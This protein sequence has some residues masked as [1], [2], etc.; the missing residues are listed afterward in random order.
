MIRTIAAIAASLALAGCLGAAPPPPVTAIPTSAAACEGLR[1]GFPVK[2][3]TY[4]RTADT[5][6]TVAE[7]K[8]GNARARSL[9]ARFAAACP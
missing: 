6:E 9:N 8:A 7:V 5:A 2:E 3:L 4:D 1:P